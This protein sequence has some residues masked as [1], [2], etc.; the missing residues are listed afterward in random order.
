MQSAWLQQQRRQVAQLQL[1]IRKQGH[2]GIG[3]IGN[4]SPKPIKI[5]Q[6][7]ASRESRAPKQSPLP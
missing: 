6:A 3:N 5:D 7:I 4:E 2:L 1:L